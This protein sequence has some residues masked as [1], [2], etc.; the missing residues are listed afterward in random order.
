EGQV[1]GE[2]RVEDLDLRVLPVLPVHGAIDRQVA[3]EPLRL[4]PELVIDEIV[5]RV[6]DRGHEYSGQRSGDM[7]LG[8]VEPAGTESLRPSDIAQDLGRDVAGEIGTTLGSA[9]GVLEV[10]GIDVVLIG[11]AGVCG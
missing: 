2:A 4:P 5:G 6:R 1:S 11:G 9:P 7:R 10:R 3:T 8:T